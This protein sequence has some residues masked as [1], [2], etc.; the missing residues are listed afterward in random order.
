M[1]YVSVT[2]DIAGGSEGGSGGWGKNAEGLVFRNSAV[3]QAG[4]QY[5]NLVFGGR[6]S[7]PS[8]LSNQSGAR[9]ISGVPDR[10]PEA[11]SQTFL[12]QDAKFC[13]VS[14]A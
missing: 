11:C 12:R 5:A 9:Y 7:W 4:N 8:S 10:I 13:S 1:T 2:S 6:P 3:L 14:P